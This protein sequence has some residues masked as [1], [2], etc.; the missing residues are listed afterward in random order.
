MKNLLIRTATGLVFTAA[1]VLSLVFYEK[2][3]VFF[4]LLF[5]FF[6]VMGTFELVRM[7]HKI[8]IDANLPLALL[9]SVTL[10]SIP[11]FLFA[12]TSP[13]VPLCGAVILL[14]LGMAVVVLELFRFRPNPLGNV[15]LSFL[16]AF[17]IALPFTLIGLLLGYHESSMVLSVFILIWLSDTLAYCMGRLF[18]RHKLCERISPNKTVE[19]FVFSMVLTVGASLGFYWIPYFQTP[20]FPTPWH[21]AGFAV[22]V[23]GFA[24][25]GDLVE[26][27]FKRSCSVK[28]SGS[29]LPGHGG[30]LDRFD[31][32]L[33]AIPAASIYWLIFELIR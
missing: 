5:L 11:P 31:S 30:V 22:V 16:P 4:Y 12:T 1:V 33:L 27:L 24:T 21:W 26:S 23:V 6:T 3:T 13:V 19:G 17:W 29:I 15:A 18:G 2:S 25:L 8:G 28:D 10:F 20:S 14:A 7:A 9:L 32:T